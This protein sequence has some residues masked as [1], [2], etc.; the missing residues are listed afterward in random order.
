MKNSVVIVTGASQGIGVH[1]YPIGYDVSAV[2][3]L[4]RNA[5]AP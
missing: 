2:V 1:I 5:K 4:H 3:W